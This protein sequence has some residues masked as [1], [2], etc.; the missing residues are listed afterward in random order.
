MRKKDSL[1]SRSGAMDAADDENTTQ[2]MV[3]R[4]CFTRLFA[5]NVEKLKKFRSN[6]EMTDRCFAANVTER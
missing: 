1:P 5:P 6:P 3:N 4:L 2:A